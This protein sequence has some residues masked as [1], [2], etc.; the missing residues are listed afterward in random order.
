M[1]DLFLRRK[2]IPYHEQSSQTA[3]SSSAD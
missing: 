3:R 1:A 2:E